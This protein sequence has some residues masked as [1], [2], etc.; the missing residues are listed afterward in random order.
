MEC[1]DLEECFAM[2]QALVKFSRSECV[3][4]LFEGRKLIGH[5]SF[6][7]LLEP[8][9]L[10][11]MLDDHGWSFTDEPIGGWKVSFPCGFENCGVDHGTWG[12]WQHAPVRRV[13]RAIGAAR[14]DLM[15]A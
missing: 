3:N 11:A 2:R 9:I 7:V 6:D 5:K 13:T 4:Y 1:L 10:C 12:S 8:K 15:N 14:I